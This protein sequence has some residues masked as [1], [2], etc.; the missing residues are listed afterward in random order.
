MVNAIILAV[1]YLI[2][3][4]LLVLPLFFGGSGS[5][6]RHN[7]W[8]VHLTAGAIIISALILTFVVILTSGRKDS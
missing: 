8:V 2:G 7:V 4:T 5:D 3:G 6:G 1:M